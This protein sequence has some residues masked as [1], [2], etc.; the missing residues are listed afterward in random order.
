MMIDSREKSLHELASAALR[1][2]GRD[3]A[4][5]PGG[6]RIAQHGATGFTVRLDGPGQ[7]REV[8]A[9]FAPPQLVR[10]TRTWRGTHVL[11]V[12]APLKVLEISWNAD[13]PFRIFNFSRGAWEATLTAWAEKGKG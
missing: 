11:S 13:E 4:P 3:G 5:S 6:A 10:R 7:P 9:E 8:P 12:R 1:V 2:V